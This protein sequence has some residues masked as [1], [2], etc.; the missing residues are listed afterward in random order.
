MLQRQVQMRHQAGFRGDGEHQVV[1]GLDRVDRTDPE[2]RQVRHQT[3][4]AHHQIAQTRRAG[5]VAAP[6]GQVHTG[7]HHLVVAAIHQPPDLIHDDARRDGARI[8]TAKRDDA[9]G[10]AMVAA[11]L[12]L[13]IGAGARAEAVDQVPGGFGDGHDVVDLHRLGLPYEIG[14]DP[15]PCP[16]L[17]LFG[18]A[19]HQVDLAHV[20]E[21]PGLRLRGAAGD[22][23]PRVR[24]RAAE[25]AD[26][27]A[28]FP[29]GLSGHGAGVDDDGILDTGGGGQFP[30]RLGLVGVQAAAQRVK[31]GG[32]AVHLEAPEEFGGQH[33][34]KDMGSWARS[35]RPRFRAS[36][37]RS[38]R[39]RASGALRARSVRVAR[40]P[41]PRRRRTSPRP[42]SRPCPVP[43]RAC[44][45]GR[46]R[47]GSRTA[48]WYVRGRGDAPRFPRR[49]S[50]GPQPRHPR[51]RRCNAGCPWRSRPDRPG[52]AGAACRRPRPAGY[53]PSRSSDGPC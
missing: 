40:R 34:G 47:S 45:D 32:A 41:R 26:L 22:D 23:E 20:A 24:V 37:P 33:A 16:G 49:A 27:L 25:L 13:N 6:A 2:A 4:D 35:S 53:R 30:H 46:G 31:D 51:R 48:R 39:R 21:G 50:R 42:A 17:H 52:R 44:A 5:Q 38:R 8:P 7:Q 11:V 10:A 3:Q 14:G 29:N 43:R 15:G 28:C 12:H 19:D 18:V 1:V 36:P 9:E